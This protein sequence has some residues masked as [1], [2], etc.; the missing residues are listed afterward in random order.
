VAGLD[1]DVVVY[2]V[3]TAARPAD[4]L[5]HCQRVRALLLLNVAIPSLRV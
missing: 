1:A 5:V 3:E 2:D 4:S